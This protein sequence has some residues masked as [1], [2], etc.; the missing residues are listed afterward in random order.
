MATTK[1]NRIINQIKTPTAR[2][3]SQ[4]EEFVSPSFVV[5]P[6]GFRGVTL[7]IQES[8]GQGKLF[9]GRLI[10]EELKLNEYSFCE[11][12]YSF[13]FDN[14]LEVIVFFHKKHKD[15]LYSLVSGPNGTYAVTATLLKN[16]LKEREFN[17]DNFVPLRMELDTFE[18][19][20]AK[21]RVNLLNRA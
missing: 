12:R 2:L 1:T 9:F 4:W 18:A 17:V 16:A 21:F 6:R 15:G 13:G 10:S 8:N 3:K 5:K 20:Y 7:S 11:Y 14:V 19:P